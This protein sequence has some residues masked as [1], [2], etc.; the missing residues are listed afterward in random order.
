MTK[1][2]RL[3]ARRKLAPEDIPPR[4]APGYLHPGD[5]IN[6]LSEEFLHITLPTLHQVV[7]TIIETITQRIEDEG[8]AALPHI[9]VVRYRRTPEQR[10]EKPHLLGRDV[11][12]EGV[13]FTVTPC[14]TLRN[15]LNP[16]LTAPWHPQPFKTVQWREWG[17]EVKRIAP[18][19]KNR[20]R[21]AA[22][23][24]PARR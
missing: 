2:P 6:I 10:L 14:M 7:Y 19:V 1:R 9:G 18:A 20:K 17:F 4:K 23:V 16:H 21:K 3:T 5:L 8:G 24:R 13:R 15:R 11:I 12:P 22:G